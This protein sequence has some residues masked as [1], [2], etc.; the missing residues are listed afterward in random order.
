MSIIISVI[1][2]I[3]LDKATYADKVYAAAQNR[4]LEVCEALS[5]CESLEIKKA[6]L[7]NE[8][9]PFYKKY[10]WFHNDSE[11]EIKDTIWRLG[12]FEVKNNRSEN[13]VCVFLRIIFAGPYDVKNKELMDAIF[14]SWYFFSK[15]TKYDSDCWHTVMAQKYIKENIFGTSKENMNWCFESIFCVAN[16]FLDD[17]EK[18]E[19]FEDDLKYNVRG[20]FI[21]YIELFMKYTEKKFPEGVSKYQWYTLLGKIFYLVEEEKIINENDLLEAIKKNNQADEKIFSQA[22]E[23]FKRCCG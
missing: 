8:N 2:H 20:R 18:A 22:Y 7:R 19:L 17:K 11:K 1:R 3:P 4:N 13:A 10:Y 16:M 5:K 14:T 15:L 21:S 12:M 23:C 6:L 9:I